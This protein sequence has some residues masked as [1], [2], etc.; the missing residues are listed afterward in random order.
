MRTTARK[1]ELEDREGLLFVKGEGRPL[2]YLFFMSGVSYEP[3]LGGLAVDE[4]AADRHNK[5]LD[6]AILKGLDEACEVGQGGSFYLRWR[7]RGRHVVVTWMGV[8]VTTDVVVDGRNVAFKRKGKTFKGRRRADEA[9]DL[10]DFVRV[11]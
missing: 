2:G 8:E 11:Q 7:G 1:V 9:G 10:F 3:D 6:A 4:K 5:T